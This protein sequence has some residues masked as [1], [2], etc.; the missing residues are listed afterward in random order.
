MIREALEQS[1]VAGLI[2]WTDGQDEES[3]IQRAWV[4]V[5]IDSDRSAADQLRR[6]L[7]IRSSSPYRLQQLKST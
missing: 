5:Y 2:G 6:Q 7:C 1:G 3:I 4:S